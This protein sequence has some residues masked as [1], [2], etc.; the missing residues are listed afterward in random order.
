MKYRLD[1]VTN[2]SSSSFVCN[3]CNHVESGYDMCLSE[4][5]MHYC[6]NGHTFCEDHTFAE[7]KELAIALLKNMKEKYIKFSYNKDKIP[8]IEEVLKAI[9][10]ED[11]DDYEQIFEEYELRDNYPV[12][13]CPICSH[14]HIREGE[15]L[16]YALN[17]L[18]IKKE[19]LF[20]EII[21]V[22]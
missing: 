21:N 2:S 5:E 15:A 20:I 22:R 7:N 17:K 12:E 19:A 13:F 16:D 11:Y 1:Y 6:D 9:G 14:H 18:G 4:A 10:Y 3:V 8:E